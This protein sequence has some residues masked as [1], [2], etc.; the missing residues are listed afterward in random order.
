MRAAKNET[1]GS[2][3]KTMT[4]IIDISGVNNGRPSAPLFS[5]PSPSFVLLEEFFVFSPNV[6]P[7]IVG[8][9]FVKTTPPG[10]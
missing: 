1:T 2:K 4:T 6:F 3:E 10:S 8:T 5:L 7:Q 9:I